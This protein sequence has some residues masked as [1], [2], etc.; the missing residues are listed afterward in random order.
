MI[1]GHDSIEGGW[2][3]SQGVDGW[4]SAASDINQGGA[5][6]DPF[7]YTGGSLLTPWTEEF[8]WSGGTP[9]G[10]SPPK[11]DRFNFEKFNYNAPSIP[12]IEAMTL[13]AR[14]DFAFTFDANEDPGAKYRQQQSQ[15]AIENSAAAR[16]NLLTGSTLARLQENA[17]GLASQEYG[18]A[19]N[20]AL[21][22]Y[23]TNL[24]KD[25]GTFDRNWGSRLGAGQANIQAALGEGN[26][27]LEGTKWNYG[28]ARQGWQDD[29]DAKMRAASAASANSAASYG[30]ALQQYNMRQDNFRTNQD[31]QYS[32]LMG[33]AGLGQGGASQLGAYGSGYGNN[34]G[35]IYG[36][37]GDA[38]AAGRVGA[39]NAWAGALGGI[40]NAAMNIGMWNY[41]N[42][43]R[44]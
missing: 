2:F 30:Q 5:G 9:G 24:N 29:A 36:Q 22:T 43:D 27:K 12:R 13:E 4:E 21:Q 33:M 25:Y 3:D 6:A 34:M 19:Y 20:R 17:S 10:Y 44:G 18:N 11:L 42:Q 35:S 41:A 38:A 28:I 37:R 31:R 8:Q 39:G 7:A 15:A 14:P 1:A 40:G 32:M 23:G 16:G 26:L